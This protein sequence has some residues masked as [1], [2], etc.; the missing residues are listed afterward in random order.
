MVELPELAVL[1]QPV[2][3]QPAM[4][5]VQGLR[6]QQIFQA[7]AEVAQEAQDKEVMLLPERLGQELPQ[8]EATVAPGLTI[9]PVK[10]ALFMAVV[11]PED[12][13][14]Q[15]LSIMQ[16]VPGPKDM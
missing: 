12:N 16:A 3:E 13:Q 2:L 8:V 9:L 14:L 6:V 4:Q 10:E 5:E 15:D 1:W 11:V 7:V